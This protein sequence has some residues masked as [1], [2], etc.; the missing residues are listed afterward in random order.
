MT[1]SNKSTDFDTQHGAAVY[2]L[3]RSVSLD[4]VID[5]KSQLLGWPCGFSYHSALNELK[6]RISNN[7]VKSLLANFDCDRQRD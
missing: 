1:S 5:P 6:A 7:V 3:C 2:L 4:Q